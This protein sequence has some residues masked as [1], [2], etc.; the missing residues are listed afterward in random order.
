MRRSVITRAKRAN[1]VDVRLLD[2][3]YVI[4]PAGAPHINR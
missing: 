3:V 4:L 2:A 1:P